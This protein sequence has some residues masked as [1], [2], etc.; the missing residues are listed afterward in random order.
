VTD[1][2]TSFRGGRT[3]IVGKRIYRF[4]NRTPLC[5]IVDF[6]VRC[7]APLLNGESI[8]REHRCRMERERAMRR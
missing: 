5:S 1:G 4:M 8:C 6:G 3:E 2:R 7:N